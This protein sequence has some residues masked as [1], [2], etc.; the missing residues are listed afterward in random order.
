MSKLFRQIA[1]CVLAGGLSVSAHAGLTKD[2]VVERVKKA[3][4][5]YKKNG[6]D[7]AIEEF[8]NQSSPFNSDDAYMFGQ[9]L[10]AG[11][12]QPIHRNP[13]I[14]GKTMGEL[15]DADGRFIIKELNKICETKGAGWF[16]YKWPK[17]DNTGIDLK[18]SYVEKMT[19]GAGNSMCI[20]TGIPTPK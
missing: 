1:L 8:N 7:K 3:H 20:G 18:S 12:T 5:F 15:K 2:Q 17:P 16:D 13:K 14:R 6:K 10:D 4:D 11:A 9:L 19:D